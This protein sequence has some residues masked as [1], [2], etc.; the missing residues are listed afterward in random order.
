MQI[1]LGNILWRLHLKIIFIFFDHEIPGAETFQWGE[2][3]ENQ[4]YLAFD[5]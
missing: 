2:I 1:R 4:K 3:F 5:P